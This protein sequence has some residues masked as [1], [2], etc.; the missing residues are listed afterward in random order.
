MF[1]AWRKPRARES[2]QHEFEQTTYAHRQQEQLLDV[3]PCGEANK[4]N[5]VLIFQDS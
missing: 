1:P 5:M 3:D 4:A 2:F